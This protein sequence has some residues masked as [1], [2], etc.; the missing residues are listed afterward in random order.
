M[1]KLVKLKTNNITPF[2]HIP[3]KT[4][5]ILY[6]LA[7]FT[8]VCNFC[9]AYSIIAILIKRTY[10]YHGITIQFYSTDLLQYLAV[11]KSQLQARTEE[12]KIH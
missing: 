6:H 5:T 2:L 8:T 1:C 4:I 10:N 7:K 9:N 12:T 11:A 3:T